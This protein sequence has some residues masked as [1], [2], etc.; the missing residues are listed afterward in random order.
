MM[1]GKKDGFAVDI[2][3]KAQFPCSKP[4]ILD[5]NLPY[6]GYLTKRIYSN[7]LWK[8]NLKK[9][10]KDFI[11]NRKN[12]KEKFD[13]NEFLK[14]NRLDACICA[15]MPKIPGQYDLNLIMIFDKHICGSI[16]RNYVEV[17]EVEFSYNLSFIEDTVTY[18]VLTPYLPKPDTA[19]L[20]FRV[21]F[22]KNKFEYDTADIL[23]L[24]NSL[25]EPD[26]FINK[27]HI[28]AYSSIEGTEEINT[29]LQEKRAMSIV[30]AIKQGED[31]DL[32][33]SIATEIKTD[34]GWELFKGDVADTEFD[35]I[36]KMDMERAACKIRTSSC[37][38]KVCRDKD[39]S[40]L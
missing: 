12:K 9:A 35:T 16:R 23:P 28:S 26:F 29:M 32:R 37:K 40:C 11:A 8:E 34:N 5:Y 10:K 30:E 4:N 31:E 17:G 7:K 6:I 25:N 20:T 24:I 21:P 3:Q 1:R 2:I 18:K 22:E 15:K 19:E 33:D 38:T 14:E 27:I 39:D 36:G 13:K